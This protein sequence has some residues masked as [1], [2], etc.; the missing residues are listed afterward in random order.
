M[1]QPN[2]KRKVFLINPSFQFR[3]MA[4]FLLF[5][6]ISLILFY[7]ANYLF[8]YNFETLGH[9]LNLPE[10]HIFFKFIAKQESKLNMIFIASTA[11]LMIVQIPL[12]L[13]LSHKIAGPIFRFTNTLTSMKNKKEIEQVKCRKG[14]FF[15]E[16][17]SSFNQ[18]LDKNK[19]E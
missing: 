15:P 14:D 1:N 5:T 7:S 17:Y 9:Q 16:I 11:L 8:I 6:L 13:F 2:N 10:G 4:Y 12:G 3:F 18:Y 19:P